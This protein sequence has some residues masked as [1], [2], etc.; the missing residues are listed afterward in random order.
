[1]LIKRRD[2]YAHSTKFALGTDYIDIFDRYQNLCV[3]EGEE[4]FS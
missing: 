4:V 2:I 1:M 3:Q